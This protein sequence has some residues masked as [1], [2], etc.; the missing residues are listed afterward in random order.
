MLMDL[1]EYKEEHPMALSGGQKQRVAIACALA[2]GRE[3]LIFDEPTSG[4]NLKHMGE[5]AKSIRYLQEQ[6]K[7]IIIVTHDTEFINACCDG[8]IRIEDG[9]LEEA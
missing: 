1:L 5:V 4:L 7:T 3:I 8:I 2:S 6:R 9:H